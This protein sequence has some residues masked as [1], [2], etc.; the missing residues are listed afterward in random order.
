MGGLRKLMPITYW[1]F[2]AGGLALV[3]IPP[4]RLLLQDPI[5][6]ATLAHGTYGLVLWIAGVLG[7]FLTGLY[8]FRLLFI[9]FWGEPSAYARE[10]HHLHQGKEGPAVMFYPVA[11]LAVLSV[12]GGWIQISGL[13][14]PISDFLATSAPPLVEATGRQELVSSVFAVLFGL[15]GIGIAWWIYGA[16]RS[17]APAFPQLQRPR[18]QVLRRRAVRRRVLPPGRLDREVPP[19]LVRATGDHRVGHQLAVG[20]QESGRLFSRVQTGLLR[21]Y[22]L[23]L[24]AGSPSHRR[25]RLGA[26]MSDW[27]TTILSSSR[28]RARSHASCCRS[29]V[30]RPVPPLLVSLAEIGVWFAALQRFDFSAGLQFDQRVLVQRP[31]RLV[32][33][34]D[35]RVL[36]LARRP[37]GGRARDGDRLRL[38]DG[39]RAPRAYYGLMLMLLGAIVGVFTAQDLILF[40][41]MFEVMLI[42]LYV[43][44]GVGAALPD[45]GDLQ[46][47]R[48][49]DGGLAADARLDHRARPVAGH[50]RPRRQPDELERLD[51]PRLRS[52][53]RRQGASSV[54]RLAADAIASRRRRSPPC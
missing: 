7:A 6:A 24:A 53:V 17:E 21:L 32:P 3:G 26:L 51:L 23:A 54:P 50:V 29:A 45:S 36:A 27:L 16:R 30:T 47:R 11:V 38:L 40:Y 46:V 37:D 13:W 15:I 20:A 12:I 5:L 1:F 52:R 44:I 41:V 4:L 48:I 2:I 18:A 49:H 19:A 35:V 25:L 9:V 22:A 34:R 33:R 42:P 10:H 43:L 28:S 14:T 31:A 8:I 39:P